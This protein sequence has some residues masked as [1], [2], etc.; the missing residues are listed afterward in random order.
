RP[1]RRPGRGRGGGRWF[2]GSRGLRALPLPPLQGR[3]A[4]TFN[5]LKDPRAAL[6]VLGSE[7]FV[8]FATKGRAFALQ[9][10][11]FC[12]VLESPFIF[13]FLLLRWNLERSLNPHCSSPDLQT[14]A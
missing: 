6:S 9:N 12:D 8:N 5:R 2:A 3:R 4:G 11:V 13:D 14:E 10:T 7:L 1:R